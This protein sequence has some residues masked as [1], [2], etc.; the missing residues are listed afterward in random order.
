M[1]RFSLE[2]RFFFIQIYGQEIDANPLRS[3]NALGIC[4]VF[5]QLFW[6]EKIY[7]SGRFSGSGA[8][9]HYAQESVPDL[10]GTGSFLLKTGMRVSFRASFWD[11]NFFRLFCVWP[12]MPGTFS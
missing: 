11:F 9:D 8:D 1:F 2:F 10:P 7:G 6:G 4:W 5:F 3:Q 12:L